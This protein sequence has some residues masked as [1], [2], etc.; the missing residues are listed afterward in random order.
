M[1]L[2]YRFVSSFQA[3]LE[4]LDRGQLSMIPRGQADS[5]DAFVVISIKAPTTLP[6]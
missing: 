3:D 5:C 6:L 2:K 4:R 1:M